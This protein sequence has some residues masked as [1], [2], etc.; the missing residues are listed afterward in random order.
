MYDDEAIKAGL[1]WSMT[2]NA[3]DYLDFVCFD[4]ELL[5]LMAALGTRYRKGQM[6]DKLQ[7]ESYQLTQERNKNDQQ[8]A[9]WLEL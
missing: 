5:V 2:D 1:I 9:R 6:T 7:Q 3:R 4:K 8:F